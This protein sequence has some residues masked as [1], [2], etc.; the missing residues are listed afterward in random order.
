[1][2]GTL[3]FGGPQPISLGDFVFQGFEVPEAV[4]WGGGQQ[5]AVHK[6]IGGTR[7]IDAMGRDDAD[8]AWSGILLSPDA[9]D[10]ADELDQLRVGGLPQSLIFLGRSYLVVVRAFTADQRKFSHV[11]YRISCAVLQDQSAIG[12]AGS[13]T[14][15]EAMT[16]DVNAVMAIPAP[17]PLVV[18]QTTLAPAQTALATAAAL[19]AATAAA[20]TLQAQI[21][22]A[23]QEAIA[24]RD[25]AAATLSIAPPGA[26]VGTIGDPIA[27]AAAFTAASL[28]ASNAATGAV[29]AAYTGR[30]LVNLQGL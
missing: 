11:P 24:A 7:V 29:M 4:R 3:A 30:A 10:R 12:Y 18:V 26:V 1:M 21:V 13:P 22:L 14:P 17:A 19:D 16:D 28:A 15:L 23:N 8:V 27:T 6:L 2:S 9:S 20:N 25:G 5:L